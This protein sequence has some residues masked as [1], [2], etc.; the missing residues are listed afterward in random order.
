MTNLKNDKAKKGSNINS[1]RK[2][3]LDVRLNIC[4]NI[5]IKI[6]TIFINASLNRLGF[7]REQ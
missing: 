3:F 1:L 5:D 2:I 6:N 7:V 4:Y